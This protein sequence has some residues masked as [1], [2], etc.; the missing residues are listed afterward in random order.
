[1]TKK[2]Y[3][4]D[5][6][7]CSFLIRNKPE[8]LLGKLQ[9][10]VLSGHR[11]VISS[12]SYAELTFGAA[13]KKAS[14]KMAGIVSDFVGRLDSVLAWDKMAVECS[15]EVKINL[16]S[17]G[18]PI[19]HNDTLIA[20]HAIAIDAI[21]VTDNVREFSRVEKLEFENWVLRENH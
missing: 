8:Y 20:G 6:K 19:S 9:Q 2:I 12:I 14:P 3:M 15:T 17:R 16:E 1:M 13:N 11:I 21:L 4:L 18:I 5:T 7:I 10:V